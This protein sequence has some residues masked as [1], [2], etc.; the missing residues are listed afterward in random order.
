MRTIRGVVALCL[1]AATPAF[2][3]DFPARPIRIVV[4]YLPGGG[5]DSLGRLIAQKLTETFR[6]QAIVDNRGGAAGR[7]GAEFVAR[8][9]PD[10][11]TLLM[12]GSTVMITAPALYKTLPYDV[13]RDFAAITTVAFTSYVLVLHPAVPAH[14][15]RE[16]IALGR[17][18]PGALNYSSSGAGGPAHLAGE[19][20]QTLTKVRMVHVPYKGGSAALVSLIGGEIDLTFGNIQPTAPVVRSGRLRA[21]AV[22]S[23]AR[24]P[25]L[26]DVPTFA[27]AGVPGLEVSIYYGVL[28][29]AATPADIV[30]RLNAALVKGLNTPEVRKRLETDG[31]EL[32]TGTPEEFAKLMRSETEKWRKLIQAAGIKPE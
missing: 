23:P 5:N 22:T 11:H 14:T 2:A 3:Q 30:T 27:E 10:G 31:A 19:L 13:Q 24:S 6:Q 8:S 17:S 15:V 16:F 7:L 21:L 29:P 4:P 32:M 18:R 9:A 20:F 12:A 26:P 28:A 1:V 25:V